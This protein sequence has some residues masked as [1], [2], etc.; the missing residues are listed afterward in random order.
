MNRRGLLFKVF[1]IL[2]PVGALVTIWPLV[3]EMPPI[4]FTSNFSFYQILMVL[5]F[6]LGAI[7]GPGYLYALTSLKGKQALSRST[8]I[9]IKWS[10]DIALL[11]SLGG[12]TTIMALIPFPFVLGSVVFCN[13]LRNDFRNFRKGKSATTAN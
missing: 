9:W 11:A 7:A 6:Y 1:A 13:L 8:N 4:K 10:I 2:F 3:A 12:L 5:P